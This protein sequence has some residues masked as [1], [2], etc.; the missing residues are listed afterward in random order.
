MYLFC[1]HGLKEK[2][3]CVEVGPPWLNE[4][5]PLHL[6]LNHHYLDS[7]FTFIDTTNL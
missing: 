5:E 6:H 2:Q 3:P 7:L 4:S 1:T